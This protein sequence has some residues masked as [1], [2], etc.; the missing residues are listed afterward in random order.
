MWRL[1][2][3]TVKAGDVVMSAR[4][5]SSFAGELLLLSLLLRQKQEV[6][7]LQIPAVT[8][9]LS[10]AETKPLRRCAAG[11]LREPTGELL[12]QETE[13]STST[14]KQQEE[15]LSSSDIII[16]MKIIG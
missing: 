1:C 10:Q 16:R 11:K 5:E 13:T 3:H 14:I 9:K 12:N 6:P 15:N 7:E 2:L 8:L 4:R